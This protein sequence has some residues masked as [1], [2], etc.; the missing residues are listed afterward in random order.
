MTKI[1]MHFIQ[2]HTAD[3]RSKFRLG[4][5]LINMTNGILWDFK[6]NNDFL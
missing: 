2:F 3:F 1:Q 4:K 5:K 6:Q